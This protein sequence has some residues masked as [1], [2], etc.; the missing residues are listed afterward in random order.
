MIF[1]GWA[2][3]KSSHSVAWSEASAFSVARASSAWNGSAS[4]AA[5]I[6]SRPKTVMNHGKPPA[7]SAQRSP[8]PLGR[9]RSAARSS[10]LRR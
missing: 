10:R 7:G 6:E 3:A 4:Y 5:M 9:S 2:S 1:P 8:W